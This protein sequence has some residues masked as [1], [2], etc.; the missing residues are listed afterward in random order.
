MLV[1][2]VLWLAELIADWALL[3]VQ[4]YLVFHTAPGRHQ[5]WC[6]GP[7]R[8]RQV[9]THAGAVPADRCDRRQGA[10]GRRGRR[11]DRPGRPPPPAGHHTSGERSP[12]PLLDTCTA[13]NVSC[14]GPGCATALQAIELRCLLSLKIAVEACVRL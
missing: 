5:L 3:C 10:A 12:W 9:V 2:A 14:A 11:Q 1:A 13:G 6:R 4:L 7:H 8:E